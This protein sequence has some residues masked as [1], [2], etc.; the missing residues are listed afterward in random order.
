MLIEKIT[1]HRTKKDGT[2]SKHTSVTYVFEC[3]TCGIRYEKKPGNVSRSKSGLTFCSRKCRHTSSK[4]GEKLDIESVK[5]N[6]ERYGVPRVSQVEE[7]KQKSIKTLRKRYGEHVNSPLDVPGA[8]AR[9]RQTHIERYGQPET[10]QNPELVAKRAQTWLKKY[11]VPYRPFPKDALE[12]AMREQPIKWQSKGEIALGNLLRDL[13]G[14]ENVIA[15]K[16]IN[17]WPID[18]YVSTIDT[19]VQFDGVYW[20]ALDCDL[21]TL[22][23]ST[24]PRDQTRYKRWQSDNAQNAWF[25]DRGLRLVR[26]TDIEFKKDPAAVLAQIRR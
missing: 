5:T 23:E 9:R 16:W 3:D 25:A 8:K 15:Q 26:V 22:R 21:D 17:K 4:K 10:F 13:Y 12:K 7:F 18:F 14:D 2:P 1:V 24:L 11:G 20:H 6:I 19:Y